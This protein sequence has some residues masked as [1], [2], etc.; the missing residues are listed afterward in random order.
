MYGQFNVNCIYISGTLILGLLSKN[1]V[2]GFR[3]SDSKWH[4][5]LKFFFTFLKKGP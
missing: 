3:E 2:N 5:F 1:Y 4:K